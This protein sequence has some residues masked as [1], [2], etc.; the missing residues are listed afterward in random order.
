MKTNFNS[1]EG[2]ILIASPK[3]EDRF[4]EKSLIYI[5]M[6][7]RNGVL[8]VILN[9]EI[10]SVSN[11]ELL[12]L[13]DKNID[14]IKDEKLPIVFGGPVNTERIIALSIDKKQEQQFSSL[15]SIVLHTDIQNFVKNFII[16][17]NKSKFLLARGIS[18][19]DSNQLEDEI[20]ENSWF[21]IQPKI[22]LIFS[23]KI[24]NKW[25]FAIEQLGI[26]DSSFIAPYSGNA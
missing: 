9:H 25:S 24:K 15:Q 22:E 5:F 16:K 13:F 8:G 21:I 10:G 2:K 12:K 23:H 20:A 14:K 7:D 4:F 3:L 17:S 19:W 18:A 1:L 11:H 6:H 26:K